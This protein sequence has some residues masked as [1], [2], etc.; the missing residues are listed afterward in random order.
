MVTRSIYNWLLFVC[1]DEIQEVNGRSCLGCSRGVHVREVKFS[2][3]HVHQS[4]PEVISKKHIILLK[5][6]LKTSS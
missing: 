3:G 4:L 2:G 1:I 6:K 5:I